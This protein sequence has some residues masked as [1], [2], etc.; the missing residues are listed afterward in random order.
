MA[1]SLCGSELLPVQ[2]ASGLAGQLNMMTEY[3]QVQQYI[4]N[5]SLGRWLK[6]KHSAGQIQ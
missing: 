6:V 5:K 2:Q 4:K 3:I 1:S